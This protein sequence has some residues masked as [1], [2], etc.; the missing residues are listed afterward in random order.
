[1][2]EMP[3]ASYPARTERN[4]IDSDGTLILSH[5]PLTG[6]SALTEK[7]AKEH[8]KPFLHIDL[9]ETSRFGAAQLIAS[10]ISQAGIEILNV[11]GPRASK[12][13]DIY[14]ATKEIMRTVIKLCQIAEVMPDPSRAA[15]YLPRTVDETVEDLIPRLSLKDKALIARMD[16]DKVEYLFLS[17]G[18]HIR[19][20]YPLWG[21]NK[22]LMDSCREVAGKGDLSEDS[23]SMVIVRGLWRRLRE[24]HKLRAV[25]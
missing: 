8:K 18:G 23:A 7:A 16:G 21:S 25:K 10:W 3:T 4:V 13:P 11:A 12:D 2:L 9:T 15:P 24:S 19:T 14:Q 22:E 6:G 20:K 17:L 5:G 1:M